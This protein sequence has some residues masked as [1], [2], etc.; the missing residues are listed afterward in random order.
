MKRK[1]EVLAK[2]ELTKDMIETL[3]EYFDTYAVEGVVSIEV[4]EDRRLFLP[5]P[6]G[7]RHFLGLARL[8]KEGGDGSRSPH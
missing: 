5:L 3:I 6:W 7:G 1:P 4:I 2:A 8:E